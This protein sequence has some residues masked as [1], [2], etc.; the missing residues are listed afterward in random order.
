VSGQFRRNILLCVSTFPDSLFIKSLTF[1]QFSW[2]LASSPDSW[3]AQWSLWFYYSLHLRSH[4]EGLAV[5]FNGSIASI[6]S[7]KRRYLSCS[8]A[9]FWGFSP[10]RGDTLHTK[11]HLD[12]SSGLGTIH[13]HYRLDR[14]TDRQRSNTTY[15]RTV[16]KLWPKNRSPCA[17]GPLSV[18][19]NL[20]ATLVYCGQTVELIRM[21]LGKEV[22]LGP[23][24]I[25]LDG[26]P[27]L[28][29]LAQ[30][31]PQFSAHI[32]CGQTAR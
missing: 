19:A 27:S 26:Y 11:W 25:V 3:S 16:L 4:C 24:R 6:R 21:P 9:R 15:R 22:P 14:Q 2:F 10:R 13:Q 23:G 1:L 28:P 12:P 32:Y 17:I 8:E 31:P 7:A 20:S 30:L 18:C 29:Q 5:I